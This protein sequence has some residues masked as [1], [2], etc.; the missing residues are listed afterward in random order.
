MVPK[1]C[2]FE[3]C[4]RPHSCRGYCRTHYEQFR[5]TG[6][7]KPI[8]AW[9]RSLPPVERFWQKVDKDGP[10]PTRMT[11]LGPC[12]EWQ[13]GTIDG[14]GCFHPGDQA[15]ALAHRYSYE[16]ANGKIPAGMEIDHICRNP[17]CVKPG[18]LRMATRKQNQEHHGGAQRNSK[19]G[20]RG[21]SWNKRNKMWIAQVRHQG[22]NQFKYFHDFEDAA[23]EVVK[24]RNSVHTHNNLD[25]AA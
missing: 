14:Y 9:D 2:S 24:M 6:S 7:V 17:L 13:A 21:V 11:H 10:I 1:V 5:R 12:W 4:G 15:K 19:T 16:L 3:D 18:H 20:V 8:Q 23:R 22:V 25:R